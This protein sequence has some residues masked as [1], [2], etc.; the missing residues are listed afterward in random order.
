[1]KPIRFAH[2]LI[3]ALIF[4]LPLAGCRKKQQ[5]VTDLR[6]RTGSKVGEG[7]AS[8]LGPGG[9]LNSDGTLAMTDGLGNWQETMTADRDALAGYT[10]YFDFDSSLVKGSE[11]GRVDAVA[12]S[13]RGNGSY[14]LV[15]EGHCDER[16]TEEYNRSLGERRALALREALVERGISPDRVG[17]ISYGEDMPADFAHNDAAWAANR[18]GVFVLYVP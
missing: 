14:N 18:R 17:T 12:D 3:V 5:D 2:L 9:S 4:T 8:D 1:M 16:G 10:V 11:S 13:L 15:V 6:S 7:T